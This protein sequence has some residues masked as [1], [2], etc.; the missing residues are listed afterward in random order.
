[1]GPLND[2]IQGPSSIGSCGRATGLGWAFRGR[3][4]TG[5]LNNSITSV[6][7][8]VML[9]LSLGSVNGRSILI[10]INDFPD[11]TIPWGQRFLWRN[12][13]MYRQY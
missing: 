3:C 11:V 8:I 6:L 5:R 2:P 13:W 7:V 9:P 12:E 1:M 4:R 10:N